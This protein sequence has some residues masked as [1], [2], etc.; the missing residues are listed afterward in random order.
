MPDNK[1]PL[2]FGETKGSK[3]NCFSD[4]NSPGFLGQYCCAFCRRELPDGSTVF[5]NICACPRCFRLA[6]TLV[7]ALRLYRNRYFKH[8]RVKK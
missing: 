1:K 8:W 3:K 7:D 2:V 5:K 4:F 6:H